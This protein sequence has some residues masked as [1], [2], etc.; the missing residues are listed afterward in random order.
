MRVAIRS[1]LARLLAALL[2]AAPL[3][4]ACTQDD[5]AFVQSLAKEWAAG[6]GLLDSTGKPDYF[7]IALLLADPS[8]DPEAA[9]A[10]QAGM[11]V[12]G[13][14]DADR[15]AQQGAAEG[16]LT[17]IDAA[18]RARPSDWSYQEQK[19]ALLLAQGDAA[20]A[21]AANEKSESLV[22]DRLQAGGN[23]RTLARNMFTHRLNALHAQAI[24]APSA[25][26]IERI[27]QTQAVLDQLIA[28]Q[29]VAFCP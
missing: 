29:P 21:Q 8:S 22:R 2:V 6:K 12:K 23:C 4:T 18:I 11:V 24:R 19:A 1:P 9:A 26:L 13:V 25:E 20:A 14:E 27:N 28:G 16:D 15:L 3:L 5:F 17:K 10:L 7:N